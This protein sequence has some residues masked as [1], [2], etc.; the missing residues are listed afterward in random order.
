MGLPFSWAFRVFWC[1]GAVVVMLSA[2]GPVLAIAEPPDWVAKRL[3]EADQPRH[4]NELWVLVDDRNASLSVLRGH[5]VIEKFAPVSLGR[6]GAKTQRIRGGNVT[7]LGEFRINRLNQESRWHIFLGIDY[8]TPD[9][10]RMAYDSGIYS[11]EEYD[12]YFDH[13]RRHGA[14]PQ[15][16]ALGGAIGIHG[17]GR[18]DPEIHERFHWTQGCVAITDAQVETLM[19]LVGV[20]TRVVIR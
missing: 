6:S 18:A 12:D 20:G 1:L 10:A 5:Q 8:P 11:R 16:T 4:D 14:P 13:Y 3:L 17:L 9:H 19:E 15:D 7:P 2:S